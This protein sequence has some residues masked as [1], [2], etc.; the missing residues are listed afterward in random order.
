MKQ[1]VENVLDKGMVNVELALSD[2]EQQIFK[3]WKEFSAKNHP[4]I[5]QV[6]L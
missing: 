1:R 5:I 4:S 2:E 6:R 3:K